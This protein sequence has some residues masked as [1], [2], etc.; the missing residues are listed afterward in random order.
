MCKFTRQRPSRN[1]GE[2]QITNTAPGRVRRRQRL[3]PVRGGP[4]PIALSN[5]EN[6]VHPQFLPVANFYRL[7][8]ALRLIPVGRCCGSP[9]IDPREKTGPEYIYY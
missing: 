2:Y 6:L 5:R 9:A 4:L 1:T 7:L 8:S 3:P